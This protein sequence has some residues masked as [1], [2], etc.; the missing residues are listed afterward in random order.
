[1]RI[2]AMVVLRNES[3][4]IGVRRSAFALVEKAY[5]RRRQQLGDA[6]RNAEAGS[7]L[8]RQIGLACTDCFEPKQHFVGPR[9]RNYDDAI[10]VADDDVAGLDGDAADDNRLA[11]GSRPGRGRGVRRDAGA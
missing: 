10:D 9:E 8:L 7:E 2:S 1:M 5:A 4:S 3:E 6:P 11:D